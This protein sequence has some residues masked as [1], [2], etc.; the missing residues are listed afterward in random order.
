MVIFKKRFVTLAEKRWAPP[1]G[2]QVSAS[3]YPGVDAISF[4]QAPAPVAAAFST[5]PT[6]TLVYDLT[7]D[8][9]TLLS[10]CNATTRKGINRAAQK[11]QLVY[12]HWS[13][14]SPALID[15]FRDFFSQFASSRGIE[16]INPINLSLYAAAGI[17]DLSVVRAPDGQALT[18]HS[19]IVEAPNV[20]QLHFASSL[21][22]S[23]NEFRNLVGRGNRFHHWQDILRFK[24][25]G[26][27]HYDFGGLYMGND[28]EKKL[29]INEFK[30][31]FGGTPATTYNCDLAL[32]TKGSLYLRLRRLYARHRAAR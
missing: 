9:E 20:R 25:A 4:L 7:V 31:S 27:V 21:A 10:G 28:D 5:S 11:D 18:W 16:A 32:T 26:L 29:H 30:H 22:S 14:P 12:T 24:H 6:D 19:H 8:A 1:A 3:D 17:L 15:E 13:H 2:Q 23:D